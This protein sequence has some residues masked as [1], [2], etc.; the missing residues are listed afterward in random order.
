M[1]VI[2]FWTISEIKIEP[3]GAKHWFFAIGIK[4]RIFVEYSVLW[5]QIIF[6]SVF[7]WATIFYWQTF[8]PIIGFDCFITEIIR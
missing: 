7:D 4:I 1:I 8:L 5:K 2:F 3:Q 6:K